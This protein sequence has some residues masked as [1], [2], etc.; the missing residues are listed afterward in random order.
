MFHFS[1]IISVMV[2]G[3][4][5]LSAELMYC[6]IVSFMCGSLAYCVDHKTETIILLP[7]SCS[8]LSLL[9]FSLV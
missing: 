9:T 8:P 7:Y 3:F 6:D 5:R 4:I 1:F 2:G